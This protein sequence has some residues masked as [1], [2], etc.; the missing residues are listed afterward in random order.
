M[1]VA[2][3][4]GS[5]AGLAS[6][7]V[8]AGLV[9]AG[10][11]AAGLVAAGPAEAGPRPTAGFSIQPPAADLEVQFV[12]QAQ[13]FAGGVASY[14][15]AFGDG[16]TTTTSAPTVTHVYSTPGTYRATLTETGSHGQSATANGII[17]TVN[18]Q[19]GATQCT[20]SLS[21]AE[22]IQLL[23]ASGPIDPSGQATVHLEAAPYRIANCES[24]ILSAAGLTDT[25]FTGNL[26]VD[27]VYTTSHPKL[28]HTTCFGSTIPFIDASGQKVKSGPLPTCPDSGPTP[29]C[30]Q[31]I[32]VVGSTVTKVLVVPPGDPKVGA[33]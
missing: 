6:A 7:L 14:R 17:E 24:Q 19:F 8:V 29:P 9:A 20:A 12:A 15:W 2:K 21:D 5:G 4:W 11:V 18:C 30:V 25:G 27:L 16:S 31:S 28:V 3:R 23:Q 22:N 10:L 33:P 13:G 32:Q 1:L 26:T